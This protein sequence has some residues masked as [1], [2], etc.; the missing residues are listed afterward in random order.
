MAC[1]WLCPAC[2]DGMGD[3]LWPE[4]PI[5][6]TTCMI[7]DRRNT[8]PADAPADESFARRLALLAEDRWADAMQRMA[9]SLDRSGDL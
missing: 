5:T 4:P 3:A 7:C 6:T 2:Y 1:E 9:E 8:A